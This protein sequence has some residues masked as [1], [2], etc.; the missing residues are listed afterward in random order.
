MREQNITGPRLD[1]ETSEAMIAQR[2]SVEFR[3]EMCML[4][5]GVVIADPSRSHVYFVDT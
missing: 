3:H 2:N 5:K 4:K 1:Q